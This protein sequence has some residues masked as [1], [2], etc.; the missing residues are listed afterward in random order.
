MDRDHW[1]FGVGCVALSKPR[2]HHL[3]QRY[4]TFHSRRICP[5]IVLAEKE[6]FLGIAYMLWAFKI[7]PVPGDPIDLNEYDGL[8]GRSPV[9]FRVI[10]TPRDTFVQKVLGV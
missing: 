10:L 7:S 4:P 2:K 6:V 3:L 1:T 5:G 9:P 8:S